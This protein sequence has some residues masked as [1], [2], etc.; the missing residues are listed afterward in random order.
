[1]K[2]LLVLLAS[3]FELLALNVFML[4]LL[5]P[6][7]L[8]KHGLQT[9][10]KIEVS[11]DKPVILVYQQILWLDVSMYNAFGVQVLQPLYQLQKQIPHKVL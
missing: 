4:I 8:I 3:I 7:L 9:R 11:N 10:G 1:M 2:F 5:L 6:L